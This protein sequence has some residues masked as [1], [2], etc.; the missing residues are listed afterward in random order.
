[1][2]IQMSDLAFVDCVFFLLLFSSKRKAEFSVYSVKSDL[3]FSFYGSI[4]KVFDIHSVF[5][6]K[7]WQGDLYCSAEFI[8][9]S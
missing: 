3:L 1:M 8:I 2:F 7:F 4:L 9:L 6:V 5:C